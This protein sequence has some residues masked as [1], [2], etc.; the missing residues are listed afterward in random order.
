MSSWW[1]I[2]GIV[3]GL[4]LL[5]LIIMLATRSKE[6]KSNYLKRSE[7]FEKVNAVSRAKEVK[8]IS[9]ETDQIPYLM[10]D[11]VIEYRI[12][13]ESDSGNTRWIVVQKEQ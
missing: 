6:S 7:S 9:K 1:L 10:K 4:L 5:A 3:A 8:D 12:L 13:F 2:V 11:P